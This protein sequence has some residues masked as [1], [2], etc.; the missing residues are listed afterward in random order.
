MELDTAVIPARE[1]EFQETF[2]GE[3]RWHAVRIHGSMRPQINTHAIRPRFGI[4]TRL[5][6]L[7]AA[8]EAPDFFQHIRFIRNKKVVGRTRQSNDA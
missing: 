7:Q 4:N 3:N 2:V 8:D 1:D 6:I 5:L